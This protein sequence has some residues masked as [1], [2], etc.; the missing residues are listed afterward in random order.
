MRLHR[1]GAEASGTL[2]RRDET[3]RT[4]RGLQLVDVLVT[5]P[6]RARRL[7]DRTPHR[8]R[9]DELALVFRGPPVMPRPLTRD[10]IKFDP[11]RDWLFRNCRHRPFSRRRLSAQDISY[12]GRKNFLRGG[13]VWPLRIA[14]K[15]GTL[16]DQL[17]SIVVFPLILKTSTAP[18]SGAILR[19]TVF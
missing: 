2:P 17:L 3:R 7:D 13:S 14:E 9:V 1:G 15:S 4:R 5:A 6:C 11:C 18:F 8:Q 12:F 19:S 16:L 10:G